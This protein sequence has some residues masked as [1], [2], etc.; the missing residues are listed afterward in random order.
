MIN[1]S[2][3]PSATGVLDTI[4]EPCPVGFFSN[5]S[6]AFEKCHRWTR[7]KDLSL[8]FPAPRGAW[9]LLPFS[10]A[11]SPSVPA[12]HVHTHSHTSRMSRGTPTAN[13]TDTFGISCLLSL[14]G[15]RHGCSLIFGEIL[16]PW[17]GTVTPL[18]LSLYPSQPLL[19]PPELVF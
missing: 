16:P 18:F 15:N 1:A 17:G 5:V 3:S 10:L 2:S 13:Q 7:Y 12:P 8:V 9:D 19:P 11:T 6:S 4:C 14:G